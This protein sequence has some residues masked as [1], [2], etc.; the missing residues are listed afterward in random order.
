MKKFTYFK[1]DKKNPMIIDFDGLR[2]LMIERRKAHKAYDMINC[3]RWQTILTQSGYGEYRNLI[4][5]E[6]YLNT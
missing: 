3:N 4:L 6:C 2:N 1:I 5:R